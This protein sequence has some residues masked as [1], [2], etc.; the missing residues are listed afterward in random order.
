MASTEQ[1][2]RNFYHIIAQNVQ[3]G[4]TYAIKFKNDP[5]VY[6]GLP[7]LDFTGEDNQF[8]FQIMEPADKKG[9]VSRP[10]DSIELMKQA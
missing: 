5:V 2:P 7:V 1:T 9:I 8:S 6:V 3:K 4:D 10:I